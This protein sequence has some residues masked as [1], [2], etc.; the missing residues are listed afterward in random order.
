M[1]GDQLVAA[2]L[3]LPAEQ[4]ALPVMISTDYGEREAPVAK[5]FLDTTVDGAPCIGLET[6][7]PHIK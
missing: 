5:V 6:D 2:I 3:A 4:R 1:T 7:A